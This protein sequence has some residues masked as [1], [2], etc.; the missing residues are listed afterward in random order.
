MILGIGIDAVTIA[1]FEH[2]HLKPRQSLR[3]LFS[4]A[5]IDYCVS[6]LA[7]SAQRFAV[8]YAAREAFFKALQA[9]SSTRNNPCALPFLRVVRSVEIVRH[10]NGIP[11]C[12]VDWERLDVLPTPQLR[13]HISL[14]HTETVAQALVLI[15]SQEQ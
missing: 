11:I 15:E 14:T 3:R 2:W 6:V 8:R 1:R 13:V 9:M 10:V 4:E 5:E 12:V 7:L